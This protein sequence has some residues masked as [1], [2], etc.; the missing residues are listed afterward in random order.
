MPRV[1]KRTTQKSGIFCFW[2]HV[3]KIDGLSIPLRDNSEN[4]HFYIQQIKL[5]S[6]KMANL[7]NGPALKK[8]E[9]AKKKAW[10]NFLNRF[11]KVEKK[12]VRFAR[13]RRREK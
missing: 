4:N 8:A 1:E 11:P 10:T 3:F 13:K 7:W 9:A 5:C 12:P 2:E 6:N